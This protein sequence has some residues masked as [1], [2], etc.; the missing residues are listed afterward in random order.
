[1]EHAGTDLPVFI[2]Q[3]GPL[4]GQ[5]WLLEG[6]LLIGRDANCDLVIPDRQ[7]SRY[8]ARLSV[9]AGG[10]QLEDLNSKNGTFCNGQR[11]ADSV[12]LQDGDL[13]QVA[14]VQHFTYLTSDAT[15]PLE[16]GV[17]PVDLPKT[18]LV[19]DIRSRRVWV[20]GKEVT[21]PLSVQQFRLL[22]MLE[23]RRGQVVSRQ[24]LVDE[25]W[26]EDESVGV[27]EQAFDALVRRLRDRLL[28]LDPDHTYVITVRGHGLRLENPDLA[29]T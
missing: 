8:H 20:S 12:I 25:V 9:E 10:V 5:R 28:A 11:I 6:A 27:T 2:A 18:R 17:L 4:N 16:A 26:G 22:Q 24:D 13:V 19:L 15:M 14:L 1:M 21:P 23:Q 29:E 3:S 7:V